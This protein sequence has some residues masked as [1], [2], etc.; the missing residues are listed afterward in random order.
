MEVLHK[1]KVNLYENFL[2]ENPDDYSAKVISERTLNVK[3]ICRSAIN[4][5]K[6]PSTVDAME[7][8]VSLFLKEMAYQLM[9]GYAVNTGWF[10]ANAQVRG[11]FDNAKEQFNPAKHSV[12]FR[13]NQGDLMRK[14]I[15]NIKVQ[16]MGVGET[17]I[18]IS[19]VVDVKTG[20]VN[21]LLTP[22]GTLKI[23]GGKLKIVGDNPQVG[24]SFEDEAGNTFRVEERD[25]VVNNPSELIV[26]IPALP[27][28]KYQL[29]ICNQYSS[30][31]TLL[32]EVRPAVYEKIFTVEYMR[33]SL[34]T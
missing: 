23:R 26:H 16:V 12:L 2:T 19:H 33:C 24:V 11:V 27:V 20:S 17:G 5:A 8:N 29:A 13:F 1:I 3:E 10:T 31:N 21:D 18:I 7:H 30:S 25:I 14:E 6:A 22:G 15:P 34:T 32:T 9:D 28:G 4:R